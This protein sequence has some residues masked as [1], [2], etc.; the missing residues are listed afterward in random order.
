MF[1]L[2]N[3]QSALQIWKITYC[4]S[5]FRTCERFRRAETGDAVPDNLMPS[6]ALL[7]KVGK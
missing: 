5:N 6:G 1:P 2:F 4:T 7:R 3:L